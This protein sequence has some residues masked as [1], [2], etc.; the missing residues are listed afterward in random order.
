MVEI[1][2]S[3]T[4]IVGGTPD[5]DSPFSN[6]GQ[7]GQCWPLR[8]NWGGGVENDYEFKTDIFRA[9][10][11]REQRRALILEARKAWRYSGLISL[12]VFRDVFKYIARRYDQISYF[13][14]PFISVKTDVVLSAGTDVL[15][16]PTTLPWWIVGGAYVILT[17]G[18]TS[19][20]VEVL[21]VSS[22]LFRI[23]GSLINTFPVGTRI[24][25]ADPIR[26]QDATSFKNETRGVATVTVSLLA[27][28]TLYATHEISEATDFF[29]GREIFLKKP[30]WRE[31]IEA[32]LISDGRETV[33][34]GR[35]PIS[36]FSPI[37]YVDREYRG[38]F[39]GREID[40]TFEIIDF[41]CR[42]RGRQGEFFMP[43]G[44]ADL[45]AILPLAS[46]A[47]TL[48]TEGVNDYATHNDTEGTGSEEILKAVYVGLEGGTY[49]AKK[50][51]SV[52]LSG[53]NSV[54]TMDSNWGADVPLSQIRYISYLPLCR[55][56]GDTLTI[57]W[58]TRGVSQFN[59]TFRTLEY[60]VAE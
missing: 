21:D 37:G 44:T 35:G 33:D 40:E 22:P 18:D 60:Q 6:V 53:G 47:A 20:L 24:C 19:E 5:L 42:Q 7:V 16:V 2:T 45:K 26:V 30:N 29:D 10:K 54:L 3:A 56:A 43:T 58:P 36:V 9:R 4:P 25:R 48:T 15:S 27:D 55:F 32:K 1:A 14:D 12:D 38:A 46:G 31:G 28:P 49:I 51:S 50:I 23:H 59:L 17:H 52:A 34:V 11:G 13:P 8:I 57:Q 39:V 41:F